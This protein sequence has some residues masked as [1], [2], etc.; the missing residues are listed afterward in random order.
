MLGSKGLIQFHRIGVIQKKI[1]N[2]TSCA[3]ID[4]LTHKSLLKSTTN[5]DFGGKTLIK[6]YFNDCFKFY[7]SG[8][9]FSDHSIQVEDNT[10]S[11]L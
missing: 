8:S 10:N 2:T 4:H 6:F 9:D 3:I 7:L 11:S 5:N 1:I